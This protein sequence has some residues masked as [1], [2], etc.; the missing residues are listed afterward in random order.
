MF[1]V[2]VNVYKKYIKPACYVIFPNLNKL[3]TYS[4]VP[5]YIGS[6]RFLESQ[7]D[8]IILYKESI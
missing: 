6:L 8:L 4:L 1:N 3:C 2:F 5:Q 7:N